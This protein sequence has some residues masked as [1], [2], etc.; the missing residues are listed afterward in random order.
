VIG[1]FFP[2]RGGGGGGATG[3]AGSALC[4]HVSALVFVAFKMVPI[5]QVQLVTFV[6][7]SIYRGLF[8]TAMIAILLHVYVWCRLPQEEH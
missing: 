1:F 5:L 6:I 7:A 2:S 4:V 8:Y 3:T